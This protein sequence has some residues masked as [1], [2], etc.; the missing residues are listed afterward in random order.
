VIDQFEEVFVEGEPAERTAF[1][2]SL[3]A[4]LESRGRSL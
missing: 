2:A 3:G 4:A 1:L